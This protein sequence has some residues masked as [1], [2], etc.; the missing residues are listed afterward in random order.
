M[1][2]V[3]KHIKHRVV[4]LLRHVRDIY[5]CSAHEEVNTFLDV[6]A[7]IIN[8]VFLNNNSI[9]YYIVYTANYAFWIALLMKRRT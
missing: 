3:T 5:R 9:T 8:S 7:R 1:Y 2:I 6:M 4:E